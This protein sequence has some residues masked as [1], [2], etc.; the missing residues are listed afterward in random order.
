MKIYVDADACP[1]INEIIQ[2][3]KEKSL[4]VI[5]VRSYAHYTPSKSGDHVKEIYVDQE[6]DMV[7]FKILQLV[8]KN[9]IVITQ[10]YGLAA[11][12]LSKD[13]HVLHH[14]G[15][16]YTNNNINHLLTLRH[17]NAMARK[18][19]QKLNGPK[20]YTEENRIKF[21]QLLKEIIATYKNE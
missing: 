14:N 18:A 16:K 7:D 19:N 15:F 8:R 4:D 10:D 12:S 5:L 1:V 2:M 20:T 6:K 3:T 13:C 21:L 11:L 17:K 9:D